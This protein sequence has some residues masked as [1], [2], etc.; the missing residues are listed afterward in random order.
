MILRRRRVGGIP[1]RLIA[2]LARHVL[3]NVP[4]GLRRAHVGVLCSHCRSVTPR[5]RVVSVTGSLVLARVPRPGRL[6][7]PL[8]ERPLLLGGRHLAAVSAPLGRALL[9][10]GRGIRR[11]RLRVVEIS[12]VAVVALVSVVSVVSVA[13]L[14][15]IAALVFL[16]L[17]LLVLLLLLLHGVAL[18]AEGLHGV[19]PA[20]IV[21][22]RG[23]V[24]ARVLGTC[25]KGITVLARVRR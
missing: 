1:G 14:R 12:L 13:L 20:Q 16:L 23:F 5:V 11:R 8:A 4:C 17:L 10:I 6:L 15:V 22:R 7:R 21:T 24:D 25:T 18:P 3:H 9:R 19:D 2:L